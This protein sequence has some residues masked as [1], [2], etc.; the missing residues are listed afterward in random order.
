[1]SKLRDTNL[2]FSLT[3][4]Q[5]KLDIVNFEINHKINSNNVM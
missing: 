2:T 1:M 4:I 5:V 3:Q